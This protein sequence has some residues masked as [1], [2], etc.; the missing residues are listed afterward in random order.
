M[1][2][3]AWL[4]PVWIIGASAIGVIMSSAFGGRESEASRT[5]SARDTEPTRTYTTTAPRA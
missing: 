5:Y 3:S 2:V 1:S 4:I